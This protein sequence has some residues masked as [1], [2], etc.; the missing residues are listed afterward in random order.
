MKQS[1][2]LTI[3]AVVIFLL[4]IPLQ[5]ATLDQALLDRIASVPEDSYID[6]IVRFNDKVNP[7]SFNDSNRN[8]RTRRLVSA[9]KGKMASQEVVN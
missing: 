7:N 1:I 4:S 5:A 9:L 6:V 2:Q 8:Q 3:S